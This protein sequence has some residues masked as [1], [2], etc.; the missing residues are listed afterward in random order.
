MRVF[1]ADGG[2]EDGTEKMG[3]KLKRSR[4][5]NADGTQE[6]ARRRNRREGEAIL[7]CP[8]MRCHHLPRAP[9]L[10]ASLPSQPS[11]G[12]GFRSRRERC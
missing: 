11:G 3:F 7:P 1:S 6:R 5:I 12:R 8:L 2:E 10:C 4:Q 9:V